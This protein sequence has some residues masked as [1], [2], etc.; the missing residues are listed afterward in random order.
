MV[1]DSADDQAGL[2]GKARAAVKQHA[3]NMKR[4][5]DGENL[6]DALKHGSAMLQEL[7]ATELTPTTYYELWMAVFDEL[8]HL[9]DFIKE[10][11]AKG[12]SMVELY[13]Q[14]QYAGNVLPRLYLLITVGSVYI[15]SKEAPAKDILKDLV[16]MS[17]GVQ[18]PMRGLFLRNYLS[19]LSKDKL[20]DKNSEYEGSGGNFHDAI[21]FIL[22]NF[23]EMNRLWVRMQHQGKVKNKQRREKERQQLKILVG[24]N[25]VRLSQLEGVTLE[26]YQTDVLPKVLEEVVDCKDRLAQNYLM[27]CI[28]QVFSAEFHINTLQTFLQTCANLEPDADVISILITLM[29]RISAHVN[30]KKDDDADIDVLREAKAFQ[31]F[32]E[33]IAKIIEERPNLRLADILRL[34]AALMEF[35]TNCYPG[36]LD[37]INHIFGVCSSLLSKTVGK[38]TGDNGANEISQEASDCIL[39]LLSAP[40]NTISVR[41]LTLTNYPP[42]MKYL[43]W[44][45]QRKVASRLLKAVLDTGVS[46]DSP[47]TVDNLL[48]FISPLIKD[49]GDQAGQL[50]DEEDDLADFEA[51]QRPVGRLI[52]LFKSSDVQVQFK[53]LSTARKHFGKGGVRRIKHTLVPLCYKYLQL[54]R[55]TSSSLTPKAAEPEGSNEASADAEA[56]TVNEDENIEAEAEDATETNEDNA[57]DEDAEK[58]KG[59][60]NEDGDGGGD[61]ENDKQEDDE[62]GKESESEEVDG[63]DAKKDADN[64]VSESK[65]VKKASKEELL[66]VHIQPDPEAVEKVQAGV[67]K[68]FQYIH[69]IISALAGVVAYQDIALKLFLAAAMCADQSVNETV[70]YEFMVQAFTLYEETAD[71][72][73]QVRA[74][75]LMIGTLQTMTVFGKDNFETLITK[76]AQYS[77]RLLKKPDQ[78]RMVC[79]C[80]HLFWSKSPLR[81]LRDG[82]EP[83]APGQDGK[84]ALECLQKSLKT[85]DA[86]VAQSQHVALFIEILNRYVYFYHN[87]MDKVTAQYVTGLIAL[88]NEHL[89]QIDEESELKDKLNMTYSNTLENIKRKA[90]ISPE[91]Y[92]TIV[93]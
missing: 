10:V 51:E 38:E 31:Q 60:D 83:P 11:N 86:C 90:A 70:A 6:E 89:G 85:A 42:L 14:V 71:S 43:G 76:T 40:L 8:R 64:A 63:S 44:K 52:H 56:K 25:L 28:I 57:D 13:E 35:A 18:H 58:E 80:A 39:D 91:K 20:P 26:V 65:E 75:T 67:R 12:T 17:K 69:E 50:E 79:R 78:C 27:D 7:R 66:G 3:F 82:E 29:Q 53:I 45:M 87:N 22:L 19:Q 88:I 37:Y 23:A 34:Q 73:E 46:L 9:Y 2:L 15:V 1:F 62:D 47:E 33:Y 92:S 55:D 68:V 93:T 16:E 4:S 59:V 81:E 61:E 36:K 30:D 54:A 74:L 72:K 48:S 49:D 5:M 77:A 32:N 21:E 24:T 41:A 84:R